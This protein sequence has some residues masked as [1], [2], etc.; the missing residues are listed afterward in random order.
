[1]RRMLALLLAAAALLGMAA[2]GKNDKSPEVPTGIATAPTTE[3]TAAPTA[4]PTAEATEACLTEATAEPTEALP[5]EDNATT[6]A[7]EASPKPTDTEPTAEPTAKPTATAK[8]QPTMVIVTKPATAATSKPTGEPAAQPTKEAAAQPAE[9]PATVSTAAPT[10]KPATAATS[11]PTE[12]PA[13]AAT[14]APTKKP[15]TAATTANPTQAPTQAP[16]AAPVTEPVVA[17]YD[18]TE[19]AAFLPKDIFSDEMYVAGLVLEQSGQRR[20]DATG[21]T[22]V[23]AFVFK[24]EYGKCYEI[25]IPAGVPCVASAT[26]LTNPR[27]LTAGD[28]RT[29]T[30]AVKSLVNNPSKEVSFMYTCRT[31]DKNEYLVI[32]TGSSDPIYIG[33]RTIIQDTDTNGP[34]YIPESVGTI[35]GTKTLGDVNWGSEKFFDNMYEPWREKYPDYITRSSIGKDATGQYEMYC[36]VYE[37]ADYKTTMFLVGG[38]HGDEEVGYFALAKTMQLIADATPED[39]L[40]YALRQKVR[41]VVIPLV[42]VWSVSNSHSRYNGTGTDLN[43]DYDSLSQQESQNVMACF[44]RYAKDV[45]VVMD[46]HIANA[47]PANVALYFNFINFADNAVVNYKTTNHMYHRYLELGHANTNTDLSRVPGSY[48]KGSQYFE[49][50]I[51]NQYGVPTITVEYLT[52]QNFPV[53]FSSECM[54][55]AVETY[56]NFIIQN[57]LFYVRE[58]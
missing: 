47:S 37:P 5:T 49:G 46:F 29:G 27:T 15:A 33:E 40:L 10:E 22:D 11:A 51:W 19:D 50:R 58:E 34:W 9:K 7:T 36:Y 16:T 43:R 55:L 54:T 4:E 24:G 25:K 2:C 38:T 23:G 6:P 53:E 1:M 56:S 44:A 28:Y 32:Y 48:A 14:P 8:P 3:A 20:L 35:A 17:R 30:T 18:D 52:T 12:K 26:F 45:S 42:N 13:T 39:A 31:Y 41:F 21:R 57:G